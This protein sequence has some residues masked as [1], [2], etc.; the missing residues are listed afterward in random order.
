MISLTVSWGNVR[1][2]LGAVEWG[3]ADLKSA[4]TPDS[5]T[6][7]MDITSPNEGLGGFVA[8]DI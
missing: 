1:S 7:G 2:V 8:A 6:Y 5:S 3:V 4:Q